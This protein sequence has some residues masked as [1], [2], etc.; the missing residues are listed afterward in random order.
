MSILGTQPGTIKDSTWTGQRS[1]LLFSYWVPPPCC[2]VIHDNKWCISWHRYPV[3]R[4][5]YCNN[6]SLLTSY[7]SWI[8]HPHAILIN[9]RE[10][11]WL[12]ISCSS[13]NH[14]IFQAL[15]SDQ[16]FSMLV[17]HFTLVK[18]LLWCWCKWSAEFNVVHYTGIIRIS[19]AVSQD[20]IR[21][22]SPT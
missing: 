7:T 12:L 1:S 10:S 16:L 22:Y 8:M 17:E 19:V 15:T 20:G 4:V 18:L 9:F 6:Y 5:M 13:Q 2:D 21:V 14:I 3:T 11:N